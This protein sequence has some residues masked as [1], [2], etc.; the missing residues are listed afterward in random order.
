MATL[1]PHP[2]G[3]RPELS[4]SLAAPPLG[5]PRKNEL[6][7]QIDALGRRL[8]ELQSALAAEGTRSLPVI[9]QG[10]DASGKD[11]TIKRLFGTT[12]Q[13]HCRAVSFKRPTAT[14]LEHDSLCRIHAMLLPRGAA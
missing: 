3:L 4:D 13:A 10:R 6:E 9:L 8:D 2:L 14:D 7:D 1:S 11:G 12:G 5:L